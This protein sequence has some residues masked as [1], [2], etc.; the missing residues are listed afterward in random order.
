MITPVFEKS[1][2][3]SAFLFRQAKGVYFRTQFL[4]EEIRRGADALQPMR[5]T[6]PLHLQP[7]HR[8]LLRL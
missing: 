2:R 7:A 5:K 8:R 3:R 6:S 1:G 4:N